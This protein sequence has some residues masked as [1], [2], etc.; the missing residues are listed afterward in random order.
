MMSNRAREI[1][2]GLQP[3]SQD[4]PIELIPDNIKDI[5]FSIRWKWYPS[6]IDGYTI[7]FRPC[8]E[9]KEIVRRHV[10][11]PDFKVLEMNVQNRFP[12]ITK[13]LHEPIVMVHLIAASFGG[14]TD[15]SLEETGYLV[16]LS[17]LR[18]I[19]PDK[20]ITIAYKDTPLC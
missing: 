1:L 2:A 17:E 18:L 5:P 4:V 11:Y 3:E 6:D 19:I 10:P 7:T 8:P 12:P 20:H 14:D 9:M 13:R 15:D 16:A